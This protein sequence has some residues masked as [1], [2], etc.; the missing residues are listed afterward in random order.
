MNNIDRLKLEMNKSGIDAVMVTSEINR[1]YLTAFPSS[2][3]VLLV[4]G[5]DVWFFTDS[6]YT[7][8]A[9]QTVLGAKVEQVDRIS[10]Y[11]KRIGEIISDLGVEKLG[12]E[13]NKLSYAEYENWS[14]KLSCELVKVQKLID[15][16]RVVKSRTELEKMIHA[17]RI[18]EKSF[19]E[20]LPLIS[21]NI[22]E[23]ELSAELQY[24]FLK[25][26]A[27]NSSFDTI[28]VSGER[29]SMPHGVPTDAKIQKGFLTIDF[30]VK[31]NGWCSDT[32]RTLCVGQPTEEMRRVY[33][34]VLRAQLAGIAMAKAGVTGKEV[35]S[36]ARSVIADAGYGEYFGHSFGH[37]LGMEVHEA[38]NASSANEK[39]LPAGAVISAEPGVYLPG[40]FGVRIEDVLFI[41]EAGCENITNLS[42][43][44]III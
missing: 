43:E 30:G 25:N 13:E 2:D 21:E 41:T 27:E 9:E 39:P 11:S 7:E 15:G 3:G 18:A 17:Q 26:G 8:A 33:D 44:L 37:G 23:K 14:G 42:K 35:D 29:S 24:R 40:K 10:S 6:R 32:T 5:D 19:Q 12:I 20:I 16:L 4:T 28:V 36:A 38:P 22:T 31:L 34:A 1:Y